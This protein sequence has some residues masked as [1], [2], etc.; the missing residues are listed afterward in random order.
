MRGRVIES[1]RLPAPMRGGA[2]SA[3]VEALNMMG[4]AAT[5]KQ[6]KAKLARQVADQA[7]VRA[8]EAEA[9]AAA[10]PTH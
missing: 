3:G 7:E 10:D 8:K 1:P 4:R 2:F 6:E 9:E 5:S